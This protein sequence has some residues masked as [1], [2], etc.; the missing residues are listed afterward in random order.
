MATKPTKLE[1]LAADLARAKAAHVEAIARLGPQIAAERDR[2][3]ALRKAYDTADKAHTK[4]YAAWQQALTNARARVVTPAE[5]KRVQAEIIAA[6]AGRFPNAD[7]VKL[8]TEKLGAV[9]TADPVVV[10]ADEAFRAAARVCD[11]ARTAWNVATTP[12]GPL[13]KL[14]KELDRY[15]D[16]VREIEKQI[17]RIPRYRETAK[18]RRDEA[19]RE[20][21]VDNETRAAREALAGCVLHRRPDCALCAAEREM[22][23]VVTALLGGQS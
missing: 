16:A 12:V 5:T 19:K 21:I 1:T 20:A 4:A 13:A 14:E 10:A 9:V 2:I 17:E 6:L 15:Q 11:K 22:A 8:A 18:I 3:N 23:P 7:T